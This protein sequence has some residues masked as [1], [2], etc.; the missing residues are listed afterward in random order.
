MQNLF[1][2]TAPLGIRETSSAP[3]S[4]GLYIW[5]GKLDIG[6][7][8]WDSQKAGSNAQASEYLEKALHDHCEKFEKQEIS[9]SARAHFSTRWQGKLLEDMNYR[10]GRLCTN[11]DGQPKNEQLERVLGDDAN[12]GLLVRIIESSFPMFFGP[13]YIGKATSQTLRQRLTQHSSR[14]LELWEQKE[15]GDGLPLKGP[16]NFAERAFLMGFSPED[17]YFSCLPVISD[18]SSGSPL[19]QPEDAI[20]VAEWL[21]NRWAT[22]VLGRD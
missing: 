5:F 2:P 11:T 20:I 7:A 10:F 9:I 19:N 3:E 8:D 12:R 6:G 22:P 14:F 16:T 18:E 21:L 13:L 17:L 1:R 15:L 4:P